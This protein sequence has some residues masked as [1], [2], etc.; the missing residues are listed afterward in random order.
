[1]ERLNLEVTVVVTERMT[2]KKELDRMNGVYNELRK[3]H[4]E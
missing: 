3:E 4:K 1:M 2:F